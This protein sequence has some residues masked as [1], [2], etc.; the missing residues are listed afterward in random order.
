MADYDEKPVVRIFQRGDNDIISYKMETSLNDTAYTSCH[1]SYTD[2]DS[3]K[4]IEYTYTPNGK[5]GTG[6]TLQVNEKVRNKTEA[7]ELAKKRLREK[8]TQEYKANLKIVGDV[9][10]VAGIT[11]KLQGFQQFDRK[12]KVIRAVHSIFGGYTV[13]LTLQQVLEGY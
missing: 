3:K 6:Q 8:N 2:P 13:D 5:A 10:M 7:R 9:A 11:V 12:Y 1:V 4:T